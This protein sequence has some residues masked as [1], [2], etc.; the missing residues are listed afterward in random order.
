MNKIKLS[1]N[2]IILNAQIFYI[3]ALLRVYNDWFFCGM[4]HFVIHNYR[5]FEVSL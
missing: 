2:V 3:P 4:V 1:G 5:T